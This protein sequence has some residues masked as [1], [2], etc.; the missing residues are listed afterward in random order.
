[1]I[2]L[3]VAL[4]HEARPLIDRYRLHRLKGDHPF[5]IY[6]NV[7]FT[8]IISGPGK[9]S[10]AAA[11]AYLQ[12]LSVNAGPVAWLNFGIAG[13]SD[14]AV[15]QG[16]LAHR[17]ID[18]ATGTAYYPP[19]LFPFPSVSSD[20]IT[21]DRPENNYAHQS[22]YDMEASGYYKIALL[23]STI[24]WVH[25]YKVVSDN[26]KHPIEK[27]TKTTI[28]E[29]ILARMDEIDDM[30]SILSAEIT[31]YRQLNVPDGHLEQITRQWHFTETQLSQLKAL[32]RRGRA[33]YGEQLFSQ[34]NPDDHRGAKSFLTMLKRQLDSKPSF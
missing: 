2:H 10:S 6:G 34:L 22:A 28:I 20:L 9:I 26:R 15:G 7:Q 19:L 11:T 29:M 16:F 5:A 12:A 3:V 27:M 30:L 1:M 17:I 25:C 4:I 32:I 24:E 31:T 21:V 13:H 33:I 18:Q 8:L 23:S 14:F